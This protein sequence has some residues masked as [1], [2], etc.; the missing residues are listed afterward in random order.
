MLTFYLIHT[1]L[2]HSVAQS[3][4]GSGGASGVFSPGPNYIQ[5]S[6]PYGCVGSHSAGGS[7]GA[8]GVFTPGPNYIQSSVPYG[9]VGSQSAGGSGGASGVFS[10]GANYIQSCMH[11]NAEPKEGRNRGID[12]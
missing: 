2:Y 9:G 3:A 10:P 12:D 7:G 6:V 8:S 4:G 11:R 1:P 5:S